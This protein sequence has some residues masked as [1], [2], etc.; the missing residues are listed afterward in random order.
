VAVEV[1]DV[2]FPSRTQLPIYIY[3]YRYIYTYTYTYI[4]IYERVYNY[5]GTT[6]EG[7]VTG[8]FFFRAVVAGWVLVGGRERGIIGVCV[9]V[10][11]CE[12]VCVC[13]CVCLWAVRGA[14]ERECVCVCGP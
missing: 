14:R 10:C 11:V 9:C 5:I 7:D 6:A 12:C 4:N 3:I 8:V 13:V 1:G 2:T